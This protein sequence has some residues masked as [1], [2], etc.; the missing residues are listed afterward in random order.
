MP[1][2]SQVTLLGR[3]PVADMPAKVV[4]HLV[5]IADPATYRAHVQGKDVAICTLGVGQPTKTAKAEFLRID[6]DAVLGF[7]R[8]CKA[9]GVA[10]FT[11]LSSVGAASASRS[12]YLRSKGELEDGLCALGFDRLSL[13]QPSMILTPENR[14][15]FSQALTLAVWPW[16]N[17]LLCGPL[18]KFR[19]IR[20]ADLG[21][22]IAHN[23]TVGRAGVERLQWDDFTKA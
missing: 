13:F 15:G 3:R 4:Q 1:E 8:E 14:Y 12:F 21:A 16:L 10:H 17:P 7:G 20:V 9:A 23:L 11:L 19:G 5:D 6:R 18:R 2:V 22:S